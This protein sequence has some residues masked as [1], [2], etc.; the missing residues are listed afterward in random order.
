MQTSRVDRRQFVTMGICALAG[1]ART[2]LGTEPTSP[3]LE[4]GTAWYDPRD[5]GVLGKGWTDTEHYYDRLPAKAKGV[6]REPVWRQSLDSA[7]L[8]VLFETD[9]SEISV[10]YKLRFGKLA[11]PAMPASGVSGVDLYAK[12]EKGRW[13]WLAV[14]RPKS[15]PTVA[16][17]MASGIAP[18][19]REYLMY[20]PLYNGVDSMEIGLPESASLAPGKPRSEKPIVFYGTSINQGG[21]ASRPGMAYTAILGRRLDRP[22]LNLGVGGCGTMD[23]EMGDLLAELDAAVYVVDC[24]PN[25]STRQVAERTEPLVRRLRRSRPDTPIVLVEG[26]SYSNT[27]FLPARQRS[28]AASYA[29]LRG[30]YERLTAA[31]VKRLH[32]VHGKHLL[33]DD[34][35]GTV[36]GSHPNDLGMSR[37]AD[38]L[39]PVLRPLVP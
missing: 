20:L 8:R 16:A 23:P 33:G 19:R 1:A 11:L 13:R 18:G 5:W 34:G 26:R 14:T 28:H 21:C 24:L 22:F 9:A 12:D 27:P 4:D 39:E 7:G 3:K 38:A 2:G 36:D 30:A 29:A 35:D 32:Y 10:R 17:K 15:L 6:V 25:M 37:L 31:G